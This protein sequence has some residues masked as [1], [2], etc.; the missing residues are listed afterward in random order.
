MGVANAGVTMATLGLASGAVDGVSNKLF[1]SNLYSVRFDMGDGVENIKL[2]RNGNDGVRYTILDCPIPGPAFSANVHNNITEENRSEKA[3]E[4]EEE[5][6]CSAALHVAFSMLC[7]LHALP[8]SCFACSTLCLL[9]ASV[10]SCLRLNKLYPVYSRAPNLRAN[11]TPQTRTN[12]TSIETHPIT[13]RT[14]WCRCNF[15]CTVYSKTYNL[16]YSTYALSLKDIVPPVLLSRC[17]LPLNPLGTCWC[18]C[19]Q[20]HEEA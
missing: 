5:V 17:A 16:I 18:S 20:S 14:R 10:L 7:L 1:G 4:E 13:R 2:L 15:I 3:Q 8:A 6:V 19:S 12:T 9:H 11:S